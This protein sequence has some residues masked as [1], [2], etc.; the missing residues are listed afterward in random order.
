M[1]K[2]TLL[3]MLLSMCVA[4]FSQSSKI[5]NNW[6]FYGGDAFG[7][8]F[9]PSG[10]PSAVTNSQANSAPSASVSNDNGDLLFYLDGTTVRNGN[11]V[12]IGNLGSTN[13]DAALIVP[14][15]QNENEYYLFQTPIGGGYDYQI[16]TASNSSDAAFQGSIGSLND[17]NGAAPGNFAQS[18]KRIAAYY[19]VSVHKAWVMVLSN[20]IRILT[21]EINDTGLN[22]NPVQI[23]ANVVFDPSNDLTVGG[24]AVSPDGTKIAMSV[25]NDDA[26]ERKDVMLADFNATTGA[27][28]NINFIDISWA[29]DVEFSPDSQNLYIIASNLQA[30]SRSA[31]QTRLSD[32][33]SKSLYSFKIPSKFSRVNTPTTVVQNLGVNTANV[34][35]GPDDKIYFNNT[36]QSNTHGYLGVIDNPNELPANLVVNPLAIF[37]G[38]FIA[39]SQIDAVLPNRVVEVNHCEEFPKEYVDVNYKNGVLAVDSENGVIYGGRANT[40]NGFSLENTSYPHYDFISR[41]DQNGCLVFVKGVSQP[42][43]IKTDDSNNIYSYNKNSLEKISPD[44]S[45]LWTY[46]DPNFSIHDFDYNND[47][48]IL[49]TN[50]ITNNVE[51]RRVNYNNGSLLTGTVIIV[52]TNTTGTNTLGSDFFGSRIATAKNSGDVYVSL[53]IRS[54]SFFFGLNTISYDGN[55]TD[56]IILKYNTLFGTITPSNSYKYIDTNVGNSFRATNQIYFNQSTNHLL[57][58]TDEKVE[59]NNQNLSL[60]AQRNYPFGS[61]FSIHNKG[62]FNESLNTFSVIENNVF[63]KLK[64]EVPY[65]FETVNIS[66]NIINLYSTLSGSAGIYGTNTNH[67]ITDDNKVYIAGHSAS[68]FYGAIVSK[69]DALNGDLLN[70]SMQDQGDIL[71]E[72]I[73][74]TEELSIYPNPF[75]NELHFKEDAKNP[76]TEIFIYNSLGNLVLQQKATKDKESLDINTASLSKGIYFI[77]TVFKDGTKK[78]KQIVKD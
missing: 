27:I 72:E 77:R 31:T 62:N 74:E 57:L 75:K 22:S 47:I 1:K 10:T 21:Y 67:G 20:D 61:P 76:V 29:D 17:E 40:F 5:N 7:V 65:T 70:R 69:M 19:D 30:V 44:G 6:Y 51:I 4:A 33:I 56:I 26:N 43:N 11:H 54:G 36:S 71:L 41:F 53:N 12:S 16:I 2:T 28:S 59:I 66:T 18:E 38:T 9:N 23:S 73:I 34:L 42:M 8:T 37:L 68:S 50:T 48:L 55:D 52:N 15:V 60:V 32:E 58:A 14:S 49:G 3:A 25:R 13:I 45:S 24:M 39:S 64:D 35:L 63:Y 78:V 46:S